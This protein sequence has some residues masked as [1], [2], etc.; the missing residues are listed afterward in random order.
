MELQAAPALR[1]IRPAILAFP[2]DFARV[3]YACRV[4]VIAV[5]IGY[6]LLVGV[7]QARDLFLVF[8][9]PAI[10]GGETAK[11]NLFGAFMR[12][13][14]YFWL[15]IFLWAMMVQASAQYLLRDSAWLIGPGREMTARDR[16]IY[17]RRFR[18]LVVLMPYLLAGAT[19]L[20]VW[21]GFE[22]ALRDLPDTRSGTLAQSAR[23]VKEE[24]WGFYAA[25]LLAF[26]A[27][28]A[29]WLRNIREIAR[30]NAGI[31][32]P[33]RGDLTATFTDDPDRQSAVTIQASVY[34][35]LGALA[36]IAAA[37]WGGLLLRY[38][39]GIYLVPILLGAWIPLFSKLGEWSQRSHVPYTLIGVAAWIALIAW[40]GHPNDVRRAELPPQPPPGIV[41]ATEAWKAANCSA[42][43][44]P[45][46]ILVTTAGGASRAAFFTATVLGE[47]LDN[48]CLEP[49][50]D[51][52][53]QAPTATLLSRRIFAISGVS[54]GSLGAAQVAAAMS[55]TRG[56]ANPPCEPAQPEHYFKRLTPTSWR[57]CLQILASDDFLS[58]TV[59]AMVTGEPFLFLERWIGWIWPGQRFRDRAAILED[60]WIGSY[61]RHTR[62][63][64]TGAQPPFSSGDLA[65]S[66]SR[67][68]AIRRQSGSW[69]PLLVLNGTAEETGRR[70]LSSQLDSRLGS[71]RLFVDA[72]DV[73]ALLGRPPIPPATAGECAILEKS[74]GRDLTVASAVTNSARF[75]M[76]SPAGR[77]TSA[78]ELKLSV[79]D[80]GYFENDGA[81]TT[82]EIALAL[83]GLGLDPAVIHI[84]NE[85]RDQADTPSPDLLPEHV[86]EEWLPVVQ[87]PLNALLATRTARG[88]YALE[89][90]KNVVDPG[91]VAD[92]RNP[93]APKNFASFLVYGET[94]RAE[95][96]SFTKDD[97]LSGYRSTA[98]KPGNY[99]CF[100]KIPRDDA[101]SD[102]LKKVSMSWWLSKPV[103]EYLDRQT[104]FA[105]NCRSFLK[106]RTWLNELLPAAQKAA[107]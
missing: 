103:Q 75:P 79:V 66:F 73:N 61:R 95:A 64:V 13:L 9:G 47:L 101:Q 84:A 78:C 104:Y 22:A 105:P 55:D 68:G 30:Q 31:V 92:P 71:G 18:L 33:R 63:A 67:L 8:S 77:F 41:A 107:P 106:V 12:W 80:G 72:N 11:A 42:E 44:C 2:G 4:P 40:Y 52:E 54:G 6:F 7:N 99:P 81:T 59:L 35:T 27:H 19:Y 15:H 76:I 58:H 62:P 48:P 82:A 25:L 97:G 87:S 20:V 28:F 65:G 86:E 89:I 36:L 96:E 70:I 1:D 90:L 91:Y 38:V 83:K 43:N 46:P 16:D 60:S 29:L 100:N 23:I 69:L 56:G 49:G 5:I 85:P 39:G 3:V 51:C 26:V 53:G 57:D 17:D 21:L 14:V 10:I 98:L 50:R 24:R 93:D 32:W 88:T 45:R 34:L 94:A 37:L 102:T 74:E